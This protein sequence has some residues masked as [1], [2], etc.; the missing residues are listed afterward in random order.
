MKLIYKAIMMILLLSIMFIGV[1]SRGI[2]REQNS[3]LDN[4]LDQDKKNNGIT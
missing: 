3:V 1:G 2:S 4:N